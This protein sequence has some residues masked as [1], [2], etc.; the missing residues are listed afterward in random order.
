MGTMQKQR[1]DAS[2][3]KSMF[4]TVTIEGLA[5]GMLMHGWT[6][7]EKARLEGGTTCGV[8]PGGSKDSDLTA[9]EKAERRLYVAGGKIG[10]PGNNIYS[11]IIA[12]GR[13]IKLGK[14]K[15]TTRDSSLIPAGMW[16]QDLFCP[17]TPQAWEVDT[18]I[19]V[20]K[21]TKAPVITH[22]PLFERWSLTFTLLVD[23]EM[24]DQ[25]LVREILDLAGK[26]IGLGSFRP[27]RK[28]PFGRFVVKCIEWKPAGSDSAIKPE[29]RE[30]PAAAGV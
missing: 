22:R 11:C 26:R 8:R 19:A 4:A 28:G 25:R 27:D 20:N 17:V 6:E 13:F 10:F 14:S 29:L 23:M 2:S 3:T 24:F 30:H 1:L 15:V 7:E 21:N 18:R 9:R 5:P 16:V 12:G